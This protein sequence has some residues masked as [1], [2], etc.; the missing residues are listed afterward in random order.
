MANGI[1][2]PDSLIIEL[3]ENAMR[4]YGWGRHQY[5]IDNYPSNLESLKEWNKT[6]GEKVDTQFALYLHCS[7]KDLIDRKNQMYL[8]LQN[9]PKRS[10][11]MM[12][13]IGGYDG[14]GVDA[15]EDLDEQQ[16]NKD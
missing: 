10:Q 7:D 1:S 13:A 2:V 5:I 12:D 9:S 11:D 4:Q 6:L 16:S 8:D 14:F 15:N 3:L